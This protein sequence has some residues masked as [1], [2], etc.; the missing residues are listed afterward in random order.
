MR[1]ERRPWSPNGDEL[2]AG[3]PAAFK[4]M[5]YEEIF[6]F[7]NLFKAHKKTKKGKLRKEEV[8]SFDLDKGH[9]LFLLSESLRKKTYRIS[10]YKTFY[11]YEPKKRRVDATS[12]K[13]R[14]VQNCFV[15]NYLYPLLDKVLIEDNA[16]CRKKKGTDYARKGLISFLEEAYKIYGEEFYVLSF[17]IHHYFES[18]DHGV[19]KEKLKEIVHDEEVLSFLAMV[20]DSFG[21]ESGLPLGNQ[22]SQCFALYYLDGIDHLIKERFPWY[23]RYMDDGIILSGNKESLQ[24]LLL[25]LKEELASLKLS[26]NLKKTGVFSVRQGVTYLGFTYHLRKNGK[27]FIKIAYKKRR[28]LNRYLSKASLSYETLLS[29]RNYLKIR[30]HEYGLIAKIETLMGKAS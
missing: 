14:V 13:D 10:P 1:R 6:T 25:V 3:T 18:I 19:L 20:I 21:G 7:A 9:E 12:Y 8:E 11:I 27:P 2:A 15:D 29:Y 28:R 26:F 4:K 24:E 17:D 30:S 5:N 23:T 22:T 16:A